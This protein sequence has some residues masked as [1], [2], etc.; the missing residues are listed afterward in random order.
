LYELPLDDQLSLDEEEDLDTH[1]VTKD[2]TLSLSGRD[3]ELLVA[4]EN[5]PENEVCP[6]CP[7]HKHEHDVNPLAQDNGNDSLSA[8]DSVPL[9]DRGRNTSGGQ[10]SIGPMLR[11]SENGRIPR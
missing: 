10:A 7:V 5:Q 8:E 11:K 4:R 2:S 3:D 6:P 1:H 9:R